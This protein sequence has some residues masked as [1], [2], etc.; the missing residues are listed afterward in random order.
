MC[1]CVCALAKQP[2]FFNSVCILTP[3]PNILHYSTPGFYST[4]SIVLLDF[5]ILDFTPHFSQTGNLVLFLDLH[6]SNMWHKSVEVGC[7][8]SWV[9]RM[10]GSV[11]CFACD[12]EKRQQPET[13]RPVCFLLVQ[14]I[15]FHQPRGTT[16]KLHGRVTLLAG[17]GRQWYSK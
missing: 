11:C 13:R 2:V 5:T 1:F 14:I 15:T 7:K 17:A 9:G 6:F 10:S 4:L 8:R 12:E 3:K 16:T